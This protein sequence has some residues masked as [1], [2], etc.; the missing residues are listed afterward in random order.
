M[1]CQVG[2]L[3]LAMAGSAVGSSLATDLNVISRYW[4]Q[5]SPYA[6][7]D[8]DYFGVND[9]GVP[10]GCA[11]EQAHLLQRHAQRFGT[12]EFDD[13]PNDAAFAAKLAAS[14]KTTNSSFTGPLA[15]LNDY[16]YLLTESYLTGIGAQT[17]FALG[18]S[19]WNRYGRLLY[20]A[21]AGQVAYN[22]SSPAA[23]DASSQPVLR[24]TSQSRIWNSQ[25]SWALGFFGPSFQPVRV[26]DPTLSNWTAPFRVVVIPEGGTENNT[27]ASY[28]SCH[29]DGQEPIVDLGDREMWPYVASYLKAAT[30]RL[31]KYVPAGFNLT[32]NDTYA[33]QSLCAYETAALG[34]SAFCGL[35]TLDEWAGFEVTLDA[36]YYYDYSYGNPTGRAQGIG[37]L[38]ELLARLTNQYISVSNSSVNATI[39]DNAKDFPLG[40]KFYADFTH[41]DIIISV[42]TAMSL[43]YLRDA[44][45][46]GA[47]AWPPNPNRNFVLSHLTPFGGHLVTEVYGC[48]SADPA[49][50]TE[51]TTVYRNP[52]VAAAAA[53]ASAGAPHKFIR[54]RLNNGIL[55]LHTIRGGACAGRTDGLCA[56][57]DFL[58]S[59][60]NA[61]ALANYAYACTG[62]YTLSD[63]FDGKD[64]DGTIFA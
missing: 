53:N 63:P 36:E 62:N 64:Y 6:D 42:L 33:M 9:V 32:T 61:T 7:N 34:D 29:N 45:P 25:I 2:L 11:L 43:D 24:T 23:L 20:N 5:L 26:P 28:D 51:H 38:Q 59:Q 47:H 14:S 57:D 17:E 4:G 16:E 35:F 52:S 12:G 8:E 49:A 60:A 50:V 39:T 15:F 31:Q 18:V 22:A 44:P 56:L 21:T 40:A 3:S 10:A 54:L 13:A 1:K 48:A 37:Y 55:P 30:A 41:D 58:Q 19:F 46:L 27:L